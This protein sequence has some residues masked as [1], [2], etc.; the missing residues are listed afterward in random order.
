MHYRWSYAHD[1][2][3]L[4]SIITDEL[5]R[6]IPLP[7]WLK[8]RLVQLRENARAFASDAKRFTQTRCGA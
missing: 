7:R 1:R 5:T 4:S 2:E 3:L 6:H 8:R